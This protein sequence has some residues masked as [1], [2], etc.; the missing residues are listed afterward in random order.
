[1]TKEKKRNATQ[2][3]ATQRNCH[4]G[5][6]RPAALRR[7]RHQ[8]LG[9]GRHAA[10]VLRE[11]CLRR[12]HRLHGRLGHRHAQQPVGR[13]AIDE[14]TPSESVRKEQNANNNHQNASKAH[15]HRTR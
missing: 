14:M 12:V 8:E 1:M 10:V 2:R 15:A 3:N 7:A 5:P 9:H 6:G 11:K 4:C 13:R